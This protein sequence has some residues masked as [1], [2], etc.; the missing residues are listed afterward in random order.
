MQMASKSKEA[1]ACSER[2]TWI[3]QS[4]RT[5]LGI[6]HREVGVARRTRL[7]SLCDDLGQRR[8]KRAELRVVIHR[9]VA[10]AQQN[11]CRR[12]THDGD[13]DP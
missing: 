8:A 13:E 4:G 7:E 1:R 3:R 10:P 6:H 2:M 11:L 9:D 12:Q 5:H